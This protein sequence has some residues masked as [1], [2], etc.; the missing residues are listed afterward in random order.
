MTHSQSGI[1]D[2][3]ARDSSWEKDKPDQGT[4]DCESQYRSGFSHSEDGGDIDMEGNDT[5]LMLWRK[6]TECVLW[7]SNEPYTKREA[8]IDI[9][10]MTRYKKEPKRVVIKGKVLF[11]Q[12]GE[13]LRSLRSWAKRW[14]WT[15]PRVKRYL[16]YLQKLEMIRLENVTVTSRIIVVNYKSY[17]KKRT[18][19]V[20][21]TS[22]ERYGSVTGA[23]PNNKG[24]KG[25]KVPTKEEE[26]TADIFEEFEINPLTAD[27]LKRPE[28]KGRFKNLNRE[29]FN[30]L[31][32]DLLEKHARLDVIHQFDSLFDWLA[33]NMNGI[34]RKNLISTARNWF[35]NYSKRSSGKASKRVGVRESPTKINPRN[36]LS[37]S[38][39]ELNMMTEEE[40]KEYKITKK[41][42]ERILDMRE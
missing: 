34:K 40:Y 18:P 1:Q 22:R 36:R 14:Y 23:F 42:P 7:E 37:V 31:I 25:N 8:W 28:I 26:A 33:N 19:T 13:C 35:D 2:S 10:L 4:C 41:L 17:N 11:Y 3:P 32:V 29:S 15:V 21:E 16:L 24:N 39:D 12:R 30:R 6:I 9:L 27:L 5:F 38:S 20:T